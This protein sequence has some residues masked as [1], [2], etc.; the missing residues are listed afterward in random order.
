MKNLPN[1]LAPCGVFCGAC[2]SFNKTCIGC[3]SDSKEQKRTSK[4]GCKIRNCCYNIEEITFCIYCNQFPC[5]KY[6]KKLLDTHQE[7]PKYRYRHEIPEIFKKLKEVG[8]HNYLKLQKQKWSCL[9]C[10]GTV[11]FYHYTCSK[12]GKEV[13]D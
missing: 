3:A 6:K 7:D 13:R 8:I 11:H 10:G 9:H 4:W 2:P 5:K 12:C 1:E